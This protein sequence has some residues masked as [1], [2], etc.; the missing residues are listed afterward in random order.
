MNKNTPKSRSKKF[1]PQKG[2]SISKTSPQHVVTGS[3]KTPN[4]FKIVSWNVNGIRNAMNKYL[5]RDLLVK[6]KPDILCINETKINQD[7]I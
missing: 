2:I 6:T 7:Q 4:T 5:I 1:M 3:G